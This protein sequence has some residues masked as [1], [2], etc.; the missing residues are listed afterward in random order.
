MSISNSK[1]KVSLEDLLADMASA[2]D[3]QQAISEKTG[4]HRSTIK[5]ILENR[6][7]HKKAFADFRAMQAMSDSKF[8]D[9]WRTFAVMFETYGPEANRRIKDMVDAADKEGSDM[10][11]DLS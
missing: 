6:G 4:D 5:D 10:E 11:K 1:F 9:Y 2:E 3:T 7:Y 8:A